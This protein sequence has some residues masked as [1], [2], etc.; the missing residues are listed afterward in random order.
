VSTTSAPLTAR[1]VERAR[2]ST[3]VRVFEPHKVGLPPMG[4]YLKDMWARRSFANELSRA[5]MRAAQTN[6]FFGRLWLVINPLL[7]A[8]VYFLLVG[9]LSGSKLTAVQFAHLLVTL[10]A[11]YFVSNCVTGGATSVIK[12]AKLVM[13]QAFPR[14]LLPMSAVRT[15]FRRFAPTLFV[16]VAV[17]LIVRVPL[18]PA[19]L[20]AIPAFL[21]TM[22][23]GAG[24][25]LFFGAIQVYFR[26]TSA[27]LPYFVRIWLY[28]SPVIWTAQDVAGKRFDLPI[29][30]LNPLYPMMVSYNDALIRG[31]VADLW[32]WAAGIGWALLALIGGG[33]YFIS[34]EREFSVRL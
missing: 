19:T 16:T 1:E 23:F 33:L 25:A 24:L 7:L 29:I 15:A 28:L 27:F 6:T 13:N 5:E 22:V 34:R 18:R 20:M 17:I 30:K 14:A 26:D 4:Q 11:F 8:S 31:Q 3:E 12:G 10:F 21:I 32:M 2:Q 9:I